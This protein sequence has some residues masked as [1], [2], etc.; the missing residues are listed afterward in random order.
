MSVQSR[1]QRLRRSP[2]AGISLAELMVA[3]FVFGIL[4]TM[5]VT[6]F[7]QMSRTFTEDREANESTNVAAIGMNEMTRV[8]RSGTELPVSGQTLNNP[9]FLAADKETV[10]LYAYLD[11]NAA[12]PQPIVAQF[13]I[14]S[15]RELIENRWTASALAGGYWGFA[16]T[17]T[18]PTTTKHVAR[19]IKPWATGENYLFTYYTAAGTVI[20]IPNGGIVSSTTLRSIAAV[21]VSMTVQADLTA[22]ANPVSLQNTVGI[23]NLGISRVGP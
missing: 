14:N 6:L 7:V 15:S 4:S 9:V 18:T 23:P 12:T 21:K 20:P 10:T 16:P 13:V 8:I 2:E 22:R 17:T 1:V 3:I 19:L 11:T 5:I